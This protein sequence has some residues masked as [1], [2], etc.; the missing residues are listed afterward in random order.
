VLHPW[1]VY[2]LAEGSGLEGPLLSMEDGEIIIRQNF[3]LPKQH[4]FIV[5]YHLCEDSSHSYE[6]SLTKT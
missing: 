2:L 5:F 3:F 6:W 4:R 1:C